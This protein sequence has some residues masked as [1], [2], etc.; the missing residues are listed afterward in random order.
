M[1]K[2]LVLI[3]SILL[4][5]VVVTSFSGCKSGGSSNVDTSKDK[6]LTINNV[7]YSLENIDHDYWK[8]PISNDASAF[9]SLWINY[10][11]SNIVVS[12]IARVVITDP[13]GDDWVYSEEKDIKYHLNEIEKCFGGWLRLYLFGA[14][15]G[16]TIRIGEYTAEIVLKNG[17]VASKK[18]TVNAPGTLGTLGKTYAYTE[19]YE[20][21]ATPGPAFAAL[22]KRAT[23]MSGTKTSDQL[24]IKFKVNDDMICNGNIAFFDVNRDYIGS[25]AK[26]FID[27]Y[28]NPSDTLNGGN[29]LKVDG[30]FNTVIC[31]V[32]DITLKTD[33]TFADIY[34]FNISL[35]DGKQYNNVYY[36]AES[37]SK[38]VD[39]Q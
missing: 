36:D 35:A 34:K 1:K 32:D 14:H 5:F 3:L 24:T 21:F 22:P 39:F 12:D 26:T 9:L 8:S 6:T 18:F 15:E 2:S 37:L 19:N 23:E 10:N 25:L 29:D 28:K 38:L 27:R 11:E 20:L 33:K 31:D 4:C 17:K 16:T 13:Q 30:N 7:G